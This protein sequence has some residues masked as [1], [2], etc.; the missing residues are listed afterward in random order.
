WRQPVARVVVFRAANPVETHLLGEGALFQPVRVAL[1][2]HRGVVIA[3]RYR[4]G[5]RKLVPL[6]IPHLR[7]QRCLHEWPPRQGFWAPVWRWGL[8]QTPRHYSRNSSRVPLLSTQWPSGSN[9]WLWT[10]LPLEVTIPHTKQFWP[11]K[12]GR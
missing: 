12:G 9:A 10:N 8:T 4:P 7:K 3:R 5:G 2:R 1:H 11:C 6:C